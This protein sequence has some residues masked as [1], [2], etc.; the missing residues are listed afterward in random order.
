MPPLILRRFKRSACFVPA[1]E[2]SLPPGFRLDGE[3]LVGCYRNP[4]PR[5]GDDDLVFTATALH[6]RLGPKWTRVPW[7]AIAEQQ[8]DEGAKKTDEVSFWDDHAERHVVS[9]I[10]RHGS[11]ARFRDSFA[12]RQVLHTVLRARSASGM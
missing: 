6:Y 2:Q 5:E 3:Q 12:L 10:G 7:A 4:A 1:D 11:A 8:W 9:L